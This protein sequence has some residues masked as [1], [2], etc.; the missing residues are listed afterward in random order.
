M[1]RKFDS[2]W[3][4]IFSH[5][6]PKINSLWLPTVPDEK[7]PIDTVVTFIHDIFL[8]KE[9]NITKDTVYYHV[10]CHK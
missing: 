5:S 10:H 2:V 8:N 3:L 6:P 4:T 7:G 9:E 1:T